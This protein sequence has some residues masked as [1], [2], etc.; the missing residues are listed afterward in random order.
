MKNHAIRVTLGENFVCE[1]C[2]EVFKLKVLRDEHL[3]SVHSQYVVADNS[4]KS[5]KCR[6]CGQAFSTLQFLEQ[7]TVSSHPTVFMLP[8]L[9]QPTAKKRK[10]N[11]SSV[12]AVESS[13]VSES[14][15]N[16][17]VGESDFDESA[18]LE[19]GVNVAELNEIVAG[20]DTVRELEIS[21]S[22][23][24]EVRTDIDR[25]KPKG[26]RSNSVCAVQ[27][28]P[29]PSGLKYFSFPPDP[30]Q[31][32]IWAH[33]CNRADSLPDDP[34][35]CERHFR[36][37]AFLPDII[38]EKT[39]KLITKRLDRKTALPTE[40]L[41]KDYPSPLKTVPKVQKQMSEDIQ[42]KKLKFNRRPCAVKDCPFE[43]PESTHMFPANEVRRKKW[44]LSCGKYVNPERDRICGGHFTPDSFHVSTTG[45]MKRLKRDA[46]PTIECPLNPDNM[47]AR[48][49]LESADDDI[50]VSEAFAVRIDPVIDD[51]VIDLDDVQI[52]AININN[53]KECSVL[54][55]NDL[56]EPLFP[57]PDD[58]NRIMSWFLANNN[59]K[60]G[61]FQNSFICRR[62][63]LDSDF[64]NDLL[65]EASGITQEFKLKENAVP[66]QNF[67][68]ILPNDSDISDKTVVSLSRAERK[69]RRNEA[70]KKI[71]LENVGTQCNFLSREEVNLSEQKIANEI[72][73]NEQTHQITTLQN[74]VKRLSSDTYKKEVTREF[75]NK[76]GFSKGH[77]NCIIN[78]E[79]KRCHY[80]QSQIAQSV[81]IRGISPKAYRVSQKTSI[82]PQPS[83]RTQERWLADIPKITG[84][85]FHSLEMLKEMAK[86]SALPYYK[87]A[88]LAFDEVAI[89]SRFD[90]DP[91]TQT[92]Y[93]NKSKMQTVMMRGFV[94]P[95]KEV[96]W[97]DFDTAMTL[98][99]IKQIIIKIE[100]ATNFEIKA[101]VFDLGNHE[102]TSKN[103]IKLKDHVYYFEHPLDPNRVVYVIP[104]V[105]HLLKCLRS[106]L[107]EKGFFFDGVDLKLEHFE[108][109]REDDDGET[110]ILYKLT[111]EHL[112]CR[113]GL[114]KQRV[115]LAAQLLSRSVALAFTFGKRKGNIEWEKRARIIQIISD[116]FDV[117]NSRQKFGR[118]EFESGFGVHPT[119]QLA[120]L[121]EMENFITN[122]KIFGRQDV[123]GEEL[124]DGGNRYKWNHGILVQIKALRAL[125]FEMVE[126]GP[127]DYLLTHKQNQDCLENWF[128]QWR[129]LHG[130]STKP[131]QFEAMTRV[132]N[133]HFTKNAEFVV[134][135]P[136]VR[137]EKRG[138]RRK[139]D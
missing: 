5:F 2:Q 57:F 41:F 44:M 111:D 23:D 20:N 66:S 70:K 13:Q 22:E 128:S 136:S 37:S 12:V 4:M 21:V 116:W 68:E 133:L 16:D 127:L 121:E 53:E 48:D 1:W 93:G 42:P 38:N 19:I 43:N 28:C 60:S 124:F 62:H 109:V 94:Q 92:I 99:L 61:S 138:G 11:E 36:P 135:N 45:I 117:S 75:L 39:K 9:E 137:I 115:F 15:V 87:L 112:Y 73:I 27:T 29:N 95:W 101:T 129:A 131:S 84:Y 63:F 79:Q 106:A 105:P 40:F 47:F 52:P 98:V 103:G 97:Y 122:L 114:K 58:R 78:P 126:N 49:N 30:E 18:E 82:L 64:E 113:T 33:R 107:L 55:C 51:P 120:A 88:V 139:W 3:R 104:D 134:K 31:R 71:S 118:N 46:I 32:Q 125:Y 6:K 8:D 81:V 91:K 54:G 69:E 25:A 119:K 132:R 59:W 85:Q 108:K 24:S 123:N 72:S 76:K 80:T 26:R 35:I 67:G 10:K 65:L 17:S 100:E 56:Q 90:M 86:I 102:F 34:R 7:H 77:Q 83:R 50:S 14:A 89:S 74:E 130:A 96:V 110:K